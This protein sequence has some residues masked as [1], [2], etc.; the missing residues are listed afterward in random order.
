MTSSNC[1]FCPTSSLKLETEGVLVPLLD[2]WL[3]QLI[4]YQNICWLI[5]FASTDWFI[6]GFSSM[7]CTLKKTG[8]LW[9]KMLLLV[10]EVIKIKRAQIK[11]DHVCNLTFMKVVK[12][13]L[14]WGPKWKWFILWRTCLDVYKVLWLLCSVDFDMSCVEV[15]MLAIWWH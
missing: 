7:C 2:K 8:V 11:F 14:T 12:E 6:D 5:F 13:G 9:L 1:L 15:E 10:N 4:N 3:K